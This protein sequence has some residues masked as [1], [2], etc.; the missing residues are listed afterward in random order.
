MIRSLFA[1]ASSLAIVACYKCADP[2]CSNVPPVEPDYPPGDVLEY[3]D[4]SVEAARSPCGQACS[5]LRDIGCSDGF[6]TDAGVSCYRACV[7]K[8]ALTKIAIACWTSAASVEA[9]R[10]CGGVRCG[11]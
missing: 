9:A 10:Q 1:V 7:R 5:H 11:K 4:G 6:P 2:Q 3:P 8:A